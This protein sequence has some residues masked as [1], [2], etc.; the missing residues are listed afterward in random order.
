[1]NN[2]RKKPL[3]DYEKAHNNDRECVLVGIMIILI[4]II[5]LLNTGPIGNFLTYIGIYLFGAFYFVLYLIA[6]VSSIYL[7]VKKKNYR[8]HFNMKLL[9]SIFIFLAL[10]IACSTSNTEIKFSN[11]V[12]VFNEHMATV[13]SKLFVI[14]SI[15]NLPVVGGGFIGYLLK[16][17]L[18]TCITPIGTMVV[19]II[20]MAI[21][22]CLL[23]KDPVVYLVK[24]FVSLGKK[25]EKTQERKIISEEKKETNEVNDESLE[26]NRQTIPNNIV[27]QVST[28]YRE[29]DDIKEIPQNVNEIKEEPKEIISRAPSTNTIEELEAPKKE[30]ISSK[31]YFADDFGLEEVKEEP[32]KEFFSTPSFEEK[33]VEEPIF[34]EKIEVKEEVKEE[35]PSSYIK[36]EPQVS[37]FKEEN[38]ETFVEP[39]V[40]SKTISTPVT[41]KV[42]EEAPKKAPSNK[43]Y[44]Y[45]SYDLLKYHAHENTKAKNEFVANQ[46]LDKINRTFQQFKIGAQVISYTIGPSVTRFNVRMNEGVRVN[47]L[48]GITNEISIALNGDKSVRLEMI[49]EGRDTSSIEVGNKKATPVSFKE[50]FE[51]IKDRTSPKDKL[52]IP[53]GKDIENKVVTTSMDELPHLLVAGTTGSGKSVFVNTIITTFI[54]RNTP[55]ELKL[56]LVDPK[57]VEMTRYADMPHLLRPIIYTAEEALQMGK[58]LVEEMERRYKLFGETGATNIKEFNKDIENGITQNERL[59]YILFVLDEYADLI[60]QCKELSLPVVSLAQKARNPA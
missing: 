37:Q 29:F 17:L 25:E 13:S 55:D 5:G 18:N 19:H 16:A 60:D 6:I 14:D 52:L 42:K 40:E 1:M 44:Q 10:I 34:Q 56:I 15:S 51:A 48:S 27:P 53:L 26:Q 39:K 36:E 31:D 9:G 4:C 7:I 20:F 21:G 24:F 30:S 28:T 45:P 38:V 8:L 12:E 50:C 57:K 11:L 58:K 54:M 47:T 3:T 43:P 23:L 49:V 32:K 33:R 41:P 59:P 2:K 22:I 35:I 46:R